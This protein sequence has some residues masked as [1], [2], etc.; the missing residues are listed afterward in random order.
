MINAKRVA[1]PFQNHDRAIEDRVVDLVSRFTLEEKIGLMCQYQPAVERL[2]VKP[3]KHGTEA[4]H[5]IAWLGEATS[6]PQPIGLACT[7]NPE[8]LERIGSVIGDEARVFYQRDPARNGLTLWAPTVDM[9]R[10]PRW[11]RTEEAYGEDPYLTGELTSALVKGIQGPHPV[12][13]KAIATLKHFLGNNNEKDR[14]H[15]SASIDPRNMREYYLKAF[16]P[17]FRD[18][19]ALSMMTAYN[20]INGTPAILHPDVLGVVKGEW[21]MNGFIVSDAGD[22]IGLVKDHRY[23]ETYKEAVVASIKNGIDSITDDA[24]ITCSAIREALAEGQLEEGDLDRALTNTFRVRFL[25]GE[26]DPDERNPYAGMPDDTVGKPEHAALSLEAARESVVLLKNKHQLLPLDRDTVQRVAVIG[27]LGDAVYRDWYSGSHPYKVTPLQ[28]IQAK[29]NKGSVIFADGC[30]RVRLRSAVTGKYVGI[31]PD[32]NGALKAERTAAD[33]AEAFLLTDWGFG[34][35]TLKALSNGKYVTTDDT[36]V[37]ASAEDIWG[38]FV[39]EVFHP[40]EGQNGTM[41]LA[42]WNGSPVSLP[43]D[44]GGALRKEVVTD[45]LKEAV[46]AAEASDA[47]IIIV[48]NHPLINGKEEIDRPD[49]TLAASQERLIREVYKVNPNTIVVVIGSYPFALNW[50]DKHIPAVLYSSHAGQELGNALA[51]V[52]FGDYNPAGRLNMTWYRSVEQLPDIMDYDI[53]KGKRT[54]QYFD[55]EPLYPFGYGLSYATFRYDELSVSQERV[56]SREDITVSVRVENTGD[57]AGDEVV[58]LY[59]RADSSRVQRPLKELKGF[60]R[61]RLTPGEKRTVRFT[62]P[63]SELA[64]WDVTRD[65]YCIESG[66]YTLMVGGSSGDIRVQKKLAV[67]GDTVPPRDLTKETPAVNYDEYEGVYLDECREGGSCI[68][69]SGEAGWLRFDDADFRGGIGGFEARCT[70]GRGGG[71]IELRLDWLDGPLIGTCTVPETGG[72]TSWET[73]ACKTDEASGVR[74]VYLC[75]GG[76]IGLSRFRFLPQTGVQ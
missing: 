2:G 70:T 56:G 58:Q 45:G 26:F 38:W 30:D 24:E 66:T 52:L 48:G 60:R 19:G 41:S 7:W 50:V 6:F 17:A 51:D 71:S 67:D 16:E 61:I 72:R 5:G 63:V 43:G 36:T 57:M 20:S 75:L 27:P 37:T 54:Y 35:T 64:F 18:G 40:V 29:M 32:E 44:E 23:F 21:E 11:G 14:G 8:L 76:D 49:L 65:A 13:R 55:G 28:G 53:R 9:E 12:Y 31:T 62:V 69:L 74:T 3:Y 15:C 33:S 4:A 46:A 39:K 34:S 59:V 42:S 73:V 1:L 25:L 22:L 47:A 10:D 68:R